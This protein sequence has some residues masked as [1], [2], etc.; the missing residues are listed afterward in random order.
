MRLTLSTRSRSDDQTHPEEIDRA[1]AD[2][3]FDTSAGT[4]HRSRRKRITSHPVLPGT[5]PGCPDAR[6]S[7]SG[8]PGG[9]GG[10]ERPAAV[11]RTTG[12]GLPE[13]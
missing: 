9:P 11:P 1:D 6:Q 13:Q 10:R 8:R 4:P 2:L 5:R 12:A 7:A 3:I